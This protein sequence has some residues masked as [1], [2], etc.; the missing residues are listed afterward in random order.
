MDNWPVL[1]DIV[2]A[3]MQITALY[4]QRLQLFRQAV[5]LW[6]VLVLIEFTHA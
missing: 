2:S 3:A 5:G 6:L 4:V 1:T